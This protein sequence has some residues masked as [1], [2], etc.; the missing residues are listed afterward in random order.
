MKQA[1]NAP[2]GN[3]H[4]FSSITFLFCSN[5][6]LSDYVNQPDLCPYPAEFGL[7]EYISLENQNL[8]P[9]IHKVWVY[10]FT[11]WNY[12]LDLWIDLSSFFHFGQE[13]CLKI[14]IENL[15]FMTNWQFP[16]SIEKNP[17]YLGSLFFHRH[18]YSKH[19]FVAAIRNLF[20][21]V[22]ASRYQY[23]RYINFLRS[24]F[25][26]Q[27]TRR[28]RLYIFR[29]HHRSLSITGILKQRTRYLNAQ[30][31]QKRLPLS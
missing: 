9:V 14:I 24:T 6:A 20:K 17:I 3:F 7:F 31:D 12:F 26:K 28:Q 19:D 16:H 25:P 5:I 1:E 29:L 11:F 2:G 27:I 10:S 21:N 8:V 4:S 23:P 30:M 22:I 13:L 18:L 15:S